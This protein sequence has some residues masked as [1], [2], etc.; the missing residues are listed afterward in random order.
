MAGVLTEN[1]VLQKTKVDNIQRVRKLNVCAAQL[2]DIGVLRRASNL[3]VLSLSL[4]ELSDLGVLENCRRL[5][6]L[7]LRKNRIE[8]LNQVLHLSDIQHLSILNLADN[9]ICQDPNYRRFV[10][11]AVAS[12]KRLDDIDILPQE[13]E[14]AF[15]VF[16]NLRAIAPPPSL[17]CDPAK[18]KMRPGAVPVNSHAPQQQQQQQQYMQPRHGQVHPIPR[19]RTEG[20][21]EFSL[22]RGARGMGGSGRSPSRSPMKGHYV[23]RRSANLESSRQAYFDSPQRY[24]QPHNAQ[25]ARRSFPG[26]GGMMNFGH[27]GSALQIGP[28]ETGVVQAVKVLLSEL[29]AE[30]L[31]EVR[32]FMD[33]LR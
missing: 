8:D 31:D 30:S 16:P 24:H 11:A 32:R 12:L 2:T 6:E 1:L 9:P 25:Q 22:E 28:T 3:E 29:S 17:Y 5:S 10:I 4:N 19:Q 13:R 18:G 33:A 26:N 20:S 27:G 21:G 7:Y 15:R 14:E 23:K